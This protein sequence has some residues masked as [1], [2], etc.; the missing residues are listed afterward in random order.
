MYD[1]SSGARGCGIGRTQAP[2][3]RFHDGGLDLAPGIALI[4]NVARAHEPPR[5]LVRAPEGLATIFAAAYRDGD[6]GRGGG[7]GRGKDPRPKPND[8]APGT[9]TPP[10]PSP[11]GLDGVRRIID[12][13]G[14]LIARLTPD[15]VYE[16]ATRDLIAGRRATLP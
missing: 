9:P 13:I 6:R 1:A 15:T 8:P 5:H 14:E 11:I 16:G 7:G 3:L 2:F 10:P 4:A 12:R